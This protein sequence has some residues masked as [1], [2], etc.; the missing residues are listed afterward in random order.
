[1]DAARHAMMQWVYRP[2]LLNGEPI[3]V[4]LEVQVW[5]PKSMGKGL[6]PFNCG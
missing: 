1:V 6:V 5:F 3:E 2:T 4:V